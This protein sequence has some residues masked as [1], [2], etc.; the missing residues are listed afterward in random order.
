M[1][2]FL[3]LVGVVVFLLSLLVHLSVGESLRPGVWVFGIVIGGL[4]GAMAI[5]AKLADDMGANLPIGESVDLALEQADGLTIPQRRDIN[6][7]TFTGDAAGLD[8]L[9][10]ECR[11]RAG[12]IRRRQAE[13][14]RAQ[15]AQE[16]A[17]LAKR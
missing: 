7:L 3:G 6:H 2:R 13:E 14:I 1:H 17:L 16:T 15:E 9:A 10:E 4:M 8:A 11:S 12:N 5:L